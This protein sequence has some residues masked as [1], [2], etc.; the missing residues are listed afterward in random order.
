[1]RYSGILNNI[2]STKTVRLRNPFVEEVKSPL[3]RE[4]QNPQTVE[5]IHQ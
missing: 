1:M 3:Q 4:T 5:M 2:K